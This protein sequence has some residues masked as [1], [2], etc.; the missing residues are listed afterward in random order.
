[1]RAVGNKQGHHLN[2]LLT[3]TDSHQDWAEHLPRLLEPQGVRAIRAR[4]VGEAVEAI[5]REPIH[6]AVVNLDLPMSGSDS[7]EGGLKLLRVIQRLQPTPPSV[8]I[9]GRRFDRRV[10][11]RMLSEA[12]KLKAFSVLDLPVKLEQVLEVLRRI[13]QRHYGGHWP[14]R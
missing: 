11:D 2:V 12:L 14:N 4:S 9:R 10:D 5:D 6:A 13:L 7:E 3:D 8:V 1:M